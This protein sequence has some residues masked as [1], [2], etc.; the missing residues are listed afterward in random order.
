MSKRLDL[1]WNWNKRTRD[2]AGGCRSFRVKFCRKLIETYNVRIKNS[3]SRFLA[4]QIKV[5]KIRNCIAFLSY[6]RA[7]DIGRVEGRRD[8][9]RNAGCRRCS[10]G[11]T[12]MACNGRVCVGGRTS[13]V[14][15]KRREDPT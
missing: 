15:N 10:R 14:R 11:E 9:R 7:N 1:E 4:N 6:V 13:E 12:E 2:E 8:D 5:R 3:S